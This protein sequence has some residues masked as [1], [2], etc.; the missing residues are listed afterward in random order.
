MQHAQQEFRLTRNLR[1]K[2]HPKA[3]DVKYRQGYYFYA[4]GVSHAILLM[5]QQFP[6]D[7]EAYTDSDGNLIGDPFTIQYW[8]G[9]ENEIQSKL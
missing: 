6:D 1:Y 3:V 8:N 9:P 4:D 2:N 5:A 7:V